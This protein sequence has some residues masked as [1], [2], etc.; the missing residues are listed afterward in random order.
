LVMP[1][2]MLV[3]LFGMDFY[4]TSNLYSFCLFQ[5]YIFFN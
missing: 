4:D 5:W 2:G 3:E 1:F